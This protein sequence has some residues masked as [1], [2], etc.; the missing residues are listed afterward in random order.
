MLTTPD[1][2]RLK[3]YRFTE[4][5]VT[6]LYALLQ[7]RSAVFVLEQQCIYQ[8]MDDLDQQAVHLLVSDGADQL[9]AYARI[10]PPGTVY[11]E[12][13]IGRILTAEAFRNKGY[14]RWLITQSVNCTNSL[15]PHASIRIGA[16]AHLQSLYRACGFNTVGQPYDEDGIEHVEMLLEQRRPG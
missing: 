6:Q 7:L 16:Q 13:A 3:L 8:D 1:N 11:A 4:L 2:V 10:L 5:S 9:C 14:G 12:A 15:Y